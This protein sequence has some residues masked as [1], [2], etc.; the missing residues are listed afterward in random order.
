MVPPA[1]PDNTIAPKATVRAA[2]DGKA[3]SGRSFIALIRYY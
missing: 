1:K 2:R 3:E